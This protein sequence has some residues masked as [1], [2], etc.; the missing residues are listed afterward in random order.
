[1]TKEVY[2]I[3][4]KELNRIINE[5]VESFISE[6]S[7]NEAFLGINFGVQTRKENRINTFKYARLYSDLVNKVSN[8]AGELNRRL[9][10]VQSSQQ[11]AVSEGLVGASIKGVSKYGL[12]NGLKGAAKV[13]GKKAFKR[14]L[15]GGL[16]A[17]AAIFAG[18]PQSISQKI[19]QFRNPG[20]T[21]PE[22]VIEGYAELA[23]WM[24]E[25]CQTTQEHPEILGAAA[26]QDETLNGPQDPDKTPFMTAGEGAGMAVSLGLACAGPVGLAAAAVFDAIDIAGMLVSA[27]AERDKEGLRIVE[28]QYEYINTAIEDMNKALAQSNNP[29]TAQS[30]VRSQQQQPVQQQPQQQGQ[31]QLPNGY[32]IGKPAPFAAN[33]PAQVGRL[34]KYFGLQVTNK[35]DRNTQAAWDNWLK[36]NYQ[37]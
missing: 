2:K 21:K 26:L 34:Q 31:V 24:Q 30:V 3:S 32:V 35:W 13:A 4:G 25:I 22:E 27:G 15:V 6:N 28:K 14:T 29:Q 33:D 17:A 20:Q 19:Q 1:M 16:A 18:I 37:A 8:I 9:Q 23:G 36:Q 11:G 7:D 10:I 5:A 12:K